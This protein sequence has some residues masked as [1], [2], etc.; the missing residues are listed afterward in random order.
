MY[1]HLSNK[2][3][4]IEFKFIFLFIIYM[5]KAQMTEVLCTMYIEIL[6]KLQKKR[7]QINATINPIRNK[8]KLCFLFYRFF[9]TRYISYTSKLLKKKNYTPIIFSN[10]IKFILHNSI[11]RKF[12]ANFWENSNIHFYRQHFWGLNFYSGG[13]FVDELVFFIEN[14]V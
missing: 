6:I 8:K 12:I 10:W 5:Y 11:D 7:T 4:C 1:L 2:E 14:C 3:Y 9:Y 13:L